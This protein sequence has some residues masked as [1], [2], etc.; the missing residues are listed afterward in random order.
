MNK[1]DRP[2]FVAIGYYL[3]SKDFKGFVTKGWYKCEPGYKKE[4]LGWNPT[5]EYIYYHVQDMN[6]NDLGGKYSLLVDAKDAFNIR[7]ADKAYVKESNSNYVW[8]NFREVDRNGV[9]QLKIKYTINFY[10]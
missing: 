9:E 6:G 1:S 10:G 4:V 2:V 8:R 3:D 5:N 7:N